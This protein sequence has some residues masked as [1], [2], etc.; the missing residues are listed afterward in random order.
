MIRRLLES[1][2]PA[3]GWTLAI[4]FLLSMDTRDIITAPGFFDKLQID[5]LIHFLLFGVYSV[6]WGSYISANTSIKLKP[7]LIFLILSGSMYGLG[8]EFYQK[9]FTNR[10]FS[11]WDAL[12]D[13]VGAVAGAAVI[14]KSPYGNRG[15]NQN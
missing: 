4:F 3:I 12:A 7:L 9:L 8:M 11:M 6:L 2:W 14:K 5:K 13:A 1:I 15:R 10:M